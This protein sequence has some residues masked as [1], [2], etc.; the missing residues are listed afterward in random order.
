ML[1]IGLEVQFTSNLRTAPGWCLRC[2]PGAP[3]AMASEV[4]LTEKINVALE[5]VTQFIPLL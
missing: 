1:P 4:S 2:S 5:N 3:K